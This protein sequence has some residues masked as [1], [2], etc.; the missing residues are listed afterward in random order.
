MGLTRVPD[1]RKWI[2]EDFDLLASL[3]CHW[4]GKLTLREWLRSLRG[5]QEPAFLDA[6]DPL[7]LLLMLRADLAELWR[8]W[9][10]RREA[11]LT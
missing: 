10:P 9:R 5:I 3:G 11:P 8:R 2:V 7:P 6:D 1:G 4:D